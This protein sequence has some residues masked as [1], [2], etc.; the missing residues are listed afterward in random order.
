MTGVTSS[1]VPLGVSAEMKVG[2]HRE[3]KETGRGQG[4]LKGVSFGVVQSAH[5]WKLVC[6]WV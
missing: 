6:H 3:T 4:D 1:R 2:I 5:D